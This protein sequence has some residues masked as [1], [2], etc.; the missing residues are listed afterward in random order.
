MYPPGFAVYITLGAS[1]SKTLLIGKSKEL[2]VASQLAARHLHIY[3][4]LVDNGFDFVVSNPT[5]TAFVPVQVKYKNSRSGFTLKRTDVDRYL[6]SDAV[7]VFSSGQSTLDETYF[8]P[9]ADWLGRARQEDRNRSDGKLSVYISS[10]GEWAERFRG[11]KGL[12]LAFSSVLTEAPNPSIEGD[13]QGLS[14]SAAPHIK[15]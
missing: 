7:V 13:V 5:A 8:F 10:S 4:P 15:R 12:S 1:M 11:E 2:F 6:P 14:P 3:F 9:F